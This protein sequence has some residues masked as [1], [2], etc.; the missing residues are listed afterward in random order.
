MGI[1]TYFKERG[2]LD[3]FAGL[4]ESR[5]SAISFMRGKGYVVMG[6]G[7]FLLGIDNLRAQY[8][9]LKKAPPSEQEIA[10]LR[11]AVYPP[12][13][14]RLFDFCSRFPSFSPCAILKP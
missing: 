2:D 1:E 9:M 3:R 10:S 13:I 11:I 7:P 12:L 14:P 6:S 4:F 8:F 5:S